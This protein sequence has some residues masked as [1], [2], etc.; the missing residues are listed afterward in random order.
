[1]EPYNIDWF[2]N[3]VTWR[4][5]SWYTLL[6]QKVDIPQVL[7]LTDPQVVLNAVQVE[8]ADLFNLS[9]NVEVFKKAAA[10]AEIAG[11]PIWLQTGGLCLGIQTAFSAHLQATLHN[12]LLPCCDLPFLREDTLVGDSLQINDA[13]IVVPEGAGLGIELDENAVAKYCVG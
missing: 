12:E 4:N 13:H 5:L 10:I 9:G 1:M 6:R 2:E 8:A 7:H 11:C 3:P